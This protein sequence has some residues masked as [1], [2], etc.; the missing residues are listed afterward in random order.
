IPTSVRHH[1]GYRPCLR[2][3]E[4]QTIMLL[5]PVDGERQAAQLVFP[6][7]VGTSDITNQFRRELTESAAESLIEPAEI[8]DIID[9]VRQIHLYRRG[10]LNRGIVVLLVE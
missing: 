7:R 6:I 3:L 4:H 2:N 5:Q 10:W 8:C 9:A 1:H